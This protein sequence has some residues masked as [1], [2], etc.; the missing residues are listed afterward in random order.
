VSEIAVAIIFGYL[1]SSRG[2]QAE[3]AVAYV[4]VAFVLAFV[5]FI[6]TAGLSALWYRL[7]PPRYAGR[8]DRPGPH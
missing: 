4:A 1:A 6:A 3:I 8:P 5:A 7:V 2:A